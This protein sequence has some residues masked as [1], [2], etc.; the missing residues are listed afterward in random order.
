MNF[1]LTENGGF[2]ERL[3]FV[4]VGIFLMGSDF[5]LGNL[6]LRAGVRVCSP[7]I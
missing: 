1:D 5:V 4:I 2:R 7:W 6:F 3:L